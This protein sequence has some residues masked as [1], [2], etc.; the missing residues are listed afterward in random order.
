[1]ILLAGIV[2]VGRV[3]DEIINEKVGFGDPGTKPAAPATHL[4]I[5]DRRR[6]GSQHYQIFD[7][8]MIIAGVKHIDRHGNDRQRIELK[9]INGF[10]NNSLR[11]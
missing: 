5:F 7:F 6:G 8:F 9:P 11:G 1:M 2:K 10:R 4:S 3:I